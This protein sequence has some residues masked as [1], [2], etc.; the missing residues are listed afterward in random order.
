MHGFVERLV[1]PVSRRSRRALTVTLLGPTTVVGGIIWAVVQPW[2]ITLLH[3]HGEGFYWL[4]VEPPLWAIGA[5]LAFWL[6]IV[7]GVLQD[8]DAALRQRGE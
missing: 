7:P 8:F 5:G 3:P 6:W 1:P 4:L 2:R